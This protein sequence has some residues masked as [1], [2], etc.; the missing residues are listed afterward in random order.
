MLYDRIA[1]G[2]LALDMD[3][4]QLAAGVCV[5]RAA[6][7]GFAESRRLVAAR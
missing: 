7:E 6:G 1:S 5:V 4:G 2:T 3:A